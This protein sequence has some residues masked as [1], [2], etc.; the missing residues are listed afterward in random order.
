MYHVL[1]LAL[2]GQDC[3]YVPL[4]DGK[5][6]QSRTVGRGVTVSECVRRGWLVWN[7]TAGW[8]NRGQ[9]ELTDAGRAILAERTERDSKRHLE[10]RRKNLLRLAHWEHGYRC[11]GLWRR[12]EA[13]DRRLGRVSLGPPGLWDGVYSWLVDNPKAPGGV[14]LVE[15]EAASLKAAKAAVETAYLLLPPEAKY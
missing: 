7:P 13:G 14:P 3:T 1:T 4:V 5:G 12:D 10:A 11:H 8:Q 9:H 2:A 6:S 15:G